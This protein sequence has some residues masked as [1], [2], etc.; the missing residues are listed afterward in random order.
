MVHIF[1]LP[2]RYENGKVLLTPHLVTLQK[3]RISVSKLMVKL[4]H[5]ARH[6]SQKQEITSN[7]FLKQC[8]L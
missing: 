7:Y 5:K 6:S 3:S 2:T 8:Q 4:S 1:Y